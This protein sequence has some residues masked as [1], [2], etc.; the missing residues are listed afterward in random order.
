MT[1][2]PT[3]IIVLGA[4]GHAA[5]LI[6]ALL[7][8]SAYDI[9][10]LIDP[11]PVAPVVLGLPVLG[12]DELLP[13]L[14]AEGVR[15]AVLG[16]GANGARARLAHRLSGFGFELPVIVHASAFVASSARIEAGAVIMARAVVGTRTLV[17]PAAIVNTGA[18]IDHDGN[19]AEA[20]H[21]APGVAIAGTV[22]IGARALIG[23]GS[24]IR[25]GVTVGA[26]A[27]IGAG[28]AVVSDVEQGATVGGVPARSLQLKT[29]RSRS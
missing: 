12:G 21:V 8:T 5:V 25:P 11:A 1:T 7:S 19:L 18:V 13:E 15:A 27:I 3:R 23:V 20:V 2:S 9:I 4:G 22:S 26:D 24:S 6:E 28:S 17:G 16:L 10:G 29:T 14:H